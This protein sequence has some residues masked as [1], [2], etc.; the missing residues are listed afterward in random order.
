MFDNP[1][2][3]VS[4][5]RAYVPQHGREPQGRSRSPRLAAVHP[6]KS[7]VF[8][9]HHDHAC[10]L[11][12]GEPKVRLHCVK[13][14]PGHR[15][16]REWLPMRNDCPCLCM[17]SV[18]SRGP[19]KSGSQGPRRVTLMGSCGLIVYSNSRACPS[20]AAGMQ[21]C[22]VTS[23]SLSEPL[24]TDGR[25]GRGNM[26]HPPSNSCRRQSIVNVKPVFLHSPQRVVR[27]N[28]KHSQTFTTTS[29]AQL[30]ATQGGHSQWP[31]LSTHGGHEW[32]P[33]VRWRP[34]A[35]PTGQVLAPPPCCPSGACPSAQLT[36]NP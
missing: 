25:P 34:R 11:V 33:P 7:V 15:T 23:S 28:H 16:T 1:W 2:M 20:L 5:S 36:A 4:A 35:A 6:P 9:Q 18:C 24:K 22:I 17:H 19:G 30:F 32:Q 8:V 10:Q 31:P 29:T 27:R 12:H 26:L 14:L 3:T 13:S 21:R